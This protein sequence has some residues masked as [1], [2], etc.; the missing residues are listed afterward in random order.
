M[1]DIKD[2]AVRLYDSGY[3]G[4]DHVCKVRCAT[5]EILASSF[6]DRIYTET[7]LGDL[8][9]DML[10]YQKFNQEVDIQYK[11][12]FQTFLDS[13]VFTYKEG[14]ISYKQKE[15]FFLMEVSG[16][17]L[18]EKGMKNERMRKI[19]FESA[20]SV[21]KNLFAEFSKKNSLGIME[22]LSALG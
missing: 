9:Q 10:T 22:L 1:V 11:K 16:M 3:V 5:P 20:F 2:T 7:D 17:Y 18:L 4:E 21:G 19:M 14:I 6:K 8:G 13:K 12:S 15:R